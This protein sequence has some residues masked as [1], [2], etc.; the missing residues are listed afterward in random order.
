M[1]SDIASLPLSGLR[2]F[3]PVERLCYIRLGE[4]EA[5]IVEGNISVKAYL[6]IIFGGRFSMGKSAADAGAERLFKALA[7]RTR[8]RL[9]SLLGDD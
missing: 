1:I 9:L 4:C 3:R 5:R 2:Q 6:L 7:D 8:L